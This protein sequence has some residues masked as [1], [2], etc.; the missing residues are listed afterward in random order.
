M[1]L[2]FTAVLFNIAASQK[3]IV[4]RCLS[5]IFDWEVLGEVLSNIEAELK[6]SFAYIELKISYVNC[7]F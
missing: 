2:I 3:K 4:K 5:N 1:K 7:Y 6:N